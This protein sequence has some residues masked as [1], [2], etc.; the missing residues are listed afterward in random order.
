MTEKSESPKST[1]VGP[2]DSA[3]CNKFLSAGTLVLII[4]PSLI[5]TTTVS[6][7]WPSSVHE[8]GLVHPLNF[9]PFLM[10]FSL[11]TTVWSSSPRSGATDHW[12]SFWPY[13]SSSDDSDEESLSEL[14]STYWTNDGSIA[15][16]L[17]GTKKSGWMSVTSVFN[18]LFPYFWYLNKVE[19]KYGFPDSGVGIEVGS[20]FQWSFGGLTPALTDDATRASTAIDT[21]V[22]IIIYIVNFYYYIIII[23]IIFIS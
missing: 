10:S 6:S 22:F 20:S 2:S 19:V 17:Y 12:T 1:L 7:S 3:Y 18:W 16:L 4:F 21:Y 14:Y 9:F 13:S 23:P 15:N 11:P 5:Y 8:R